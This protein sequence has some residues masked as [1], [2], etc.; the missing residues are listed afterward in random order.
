MMCNK[1]IFLVSKF[2]NNSVCTKLKGSMGSVG[3]LFIFHSLRRELVRERER[4]VHLLT[5]GKIFI[6]IFLCILSI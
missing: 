5:L 3:G 2:R 4:G 6:Q 1:L